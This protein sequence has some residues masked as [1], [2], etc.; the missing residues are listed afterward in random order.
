MFVFCH[1]VITVHSYTPAFTAFDSFIHTPVLHKSMVFVML[2]YF[3]LVI[4]MCF[5]VLTL[6]G[7]HVSHVMVLWGETERRSHEVNLWICFSS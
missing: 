4:A 3:N 7:F 6:S 1:T 2:F 5:I